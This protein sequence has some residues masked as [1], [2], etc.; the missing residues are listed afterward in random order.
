MKKGHYHSVTC[1]NLS[2]LEV[3]K[4]GLPPLLVHY[5]SAN[6]TQQEEN[7]QERGQARLPNPELDAL[8]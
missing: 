6:G 1:L 2:S 7:H 8:E 5:K 4:A 3:R